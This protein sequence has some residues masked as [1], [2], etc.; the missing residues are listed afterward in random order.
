M[1]SN[2]D[3]EYCRK[4]IGG[5]SI[6]LHHIIKSQQC[7]LE[8]EHPWFFLVVLYLQMSFSNLIGELNKHFSDNGQGDM[9]H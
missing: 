3:Q 4:A 8:I 5:A 6:S 1:K 7:H 9:P 2:I